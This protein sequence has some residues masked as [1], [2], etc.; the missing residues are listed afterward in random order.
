[1]KEPTEKPPLL[2]QLHTNNNETSIHD[3]SSN[4]RGESRD[5]TYPSSESGLSL[6]AGK[7]LDISAGSATMLLPMKYITKMYNVIFQ[8]GEKYS[9]VGAAVHTNL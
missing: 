7:G 2:R 3:S 9:I 5:A 8:L 1:M 6:G 4:Q